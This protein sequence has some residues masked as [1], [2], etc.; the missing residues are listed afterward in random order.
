MKIS[1][2]PIRMAPQAPMHSHMQI[3]PSNGLQI[4]ALHVP[5]LTGFFEE[6]CWLQ[7]GSCWLQVAHVASKLAHFIS[8]LA[9]VSSLLAYVRFMFAY[10]GSKMALN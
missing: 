5:F 2:N 1:K 3:G 4:N 6:L 7:V 8:K 10:N 9:H